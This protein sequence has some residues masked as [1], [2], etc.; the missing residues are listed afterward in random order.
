M[1]PCCGKRMTKVIRDL[2]HTSIPKQQSPN[3]VS[4]VTLGNRTRLSVH[5][6]RP[7]SLSCREMHD[8]K[9]LRS[10]VMPCDTM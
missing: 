4:H 6:V 9:P 5:S 8:C 7:P 1:P 10:E 2:T 3:L